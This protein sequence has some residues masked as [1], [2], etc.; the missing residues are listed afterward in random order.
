MSEQLAAAA[1][2]MNVPEAIVERSARARATASGASFEDVI[3]SWAGGTPAPAAAPVAAAP[4]ESAPA[5]S[6]PTPEPAPAAPAAP[7][8]PVTT[9]VPEPEPEP[10]PEVEPLGLGERLR[11]AGRIGA[12]TGVVLGF[13]GFVMASTWLLSAA[14]L[15]G[16]EGAFEPA[17]EITTSR[18]V[19]G[20]TL[21]SIVFGVIVA[22]LSRAAAGWVAPGARLQGKPASTVGVGAGVGLVL[23]VLAGAVLTSAFSEPIEGSEGLATMQIVPTAIVVLVGGALL[24]WLTSV[25]IQVIGVPAG[26]DTD[27]AAEIHEVR[28]RLGNA[29]KIP[30]AA[31][32]LLALLVLPLG[33]IFIRS[34]EMASG[35]ASLLAII[36]AGAILGIASISA[37]RPSM[38]ITFGEFLVAVAGIGAVVLIIFAVIQARAEPEEHGTESEV[39]EETTEEAALDS[40]S[41]FVL[42]LNGGSGRSPV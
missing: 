17:V 16:E 2:A 15:A 3:S 19:L 18:L 4:T 14:S 31:A 24:G 40:G 28:G 30:V 23:G 34:N 8:V 42:V 41:G 7:A 37:S 6:A 12:W 13:L 39:T 38:S 26:L 27:E 11:L 10:E 1:Q 35:G 29:I 9:Y 32:V 21:I 20:V 36:A 33:L 22:T 25:V 5:E